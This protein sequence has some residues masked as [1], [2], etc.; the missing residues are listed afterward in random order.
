MGTGYFPRIKRP[1][2]GVEHPPKCSAEVKERVD[3]SDEPS[4]VMLYSITHTGKV[5]VKHTTCGVYIAKEFLYS[6]SEQ[7][8]VSASISVIIR[9][10]TYLL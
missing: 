9:L 1:E 4:Q 6:L 5:T 2:R 3:L 10:I 8:R 7:R